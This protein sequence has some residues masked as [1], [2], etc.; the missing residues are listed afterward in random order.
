M[1]L[2]QP[3]PKAT[4]VTRATRATPELLGRKGTRVLPGHK[5]LRERKELPVLPGPKGIKVLPDL[6]ALKG[7]KVLPDLLAPKGIKVLLELLAPKGI[8]VIKGQRAIATGRYLAAIFTRRIVSRSARGAIRSES[9]ILEMYKSMDTSLHG[10]I[11][12]L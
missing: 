12:T 8:R 2:V 11:S 7:I 4:R 6:P 9:M 5:V 10:G 1:T 3:G